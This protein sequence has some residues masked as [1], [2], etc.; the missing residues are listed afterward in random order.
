MDAARSPATVAVTDP[1]AEAEHLRA[2]AEEQPEAALVLSQVPRMAGRLPV[3]E[4]LD[5]PKH[6]SIV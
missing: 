5:V 1:A 2:R 3:P 4:A 6:G